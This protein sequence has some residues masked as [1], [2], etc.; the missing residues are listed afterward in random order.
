MTEQAQPHKT[1]YEQL[2][3]YI[4]TKGLK[5]ID[6]QTL[7][8][9]RKEAKPCTS[10]M[11]PNITIKP[12]QATVTIIQAHYLVLGQQSKHAELIVETVNQ[13]NIVGG[14]KIHIT[15][16]DTMESIFKKFDFKPLIT[17][18]LNLNFLSDGNSVISTYPLVTHDVIKFHSKSPTKVISMAELDI[19]LNQ[20]YAEQLDKTKTPHFYLLSSHSPLIMARN[21][22]RNDNFANNC[23]EWALRMCSYA[24]I[25]PDVASR[26][27]TNTEDY[28]RE[29][30]Q[31]RDVGP[32]EMAEF[33][34]SGS[35]EAFERYC[36]NLS[37][38]VVNAYV[39]SNDISSGAKERALR[40]MTPLH[41][42][43]LYNHPD[44]VK[45]LMDHG[46]DPKLKTRG[47]FPLEQLDAYQCATIPYIRTAYLIEELHIKRDDKIKNQIVEILNQP[48][49]IKT[50]TLTKAPTLFAPRDILTQ[51]T[52]AAT[53][54]SLPAIR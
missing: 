9:M 44:V 23:I 33:A 51:V 32:A 5:I 40:Q 6:V 39:S 20:V 18:I 53:T 28:V 52:D 12:G 43:C 16:A 26:H 31:F 30:L 22:L 37:P 1:L 19:M 11:D 14:Y 13:N 49:N 42:A 8:D 4:D 7:K 34:R 50:N 3:P 38:E 25:V 48:A 29:D 35:V 24:G 41:L 15:S 10:I 27:I 36:K 46:A 21:H 54:N 17:G 47:I 45:W 2:Q